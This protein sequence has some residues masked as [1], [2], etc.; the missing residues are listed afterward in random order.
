MKKHSVKVKRVYDE[1]SIEDGKR[2]L[3]DRLW[4]RGIS[5]ENLKL[6]LWIKTIAPSNELR[7]KYHDGELSFVDFKKAYIA[8]LDGN[9]ETASFIE[10]VKEFLAKDDVTL[11]YSSK[12]VEENN[13]TVLKDYLER[14]SGKK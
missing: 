6:D 11:L 1:Y 4:P 9:P 12:M 5:K 13:A 7:K 10:Q 8:E 3:C 14:N 2:I